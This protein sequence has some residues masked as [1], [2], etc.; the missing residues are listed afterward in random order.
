[1]DEETT[2]QDLLKLNLHKY[3]DDVLGMVDKAVKETSMEKT[4]KEF[5][6]TWANMAFIHTTHTRTGIKQL[7]AEE[8]LIEVLEDNQVSEGMGEGMGLK[9]AHLLWFLLRL[10]NLKVLWEFTQATDFKMHSLY[11]IL[12]NIIIFRSKNKKL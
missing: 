6:Q 2:L 5:S 8:E 3:E 7:H 10:N 12:F 11:S 1:M 9:G 4:L